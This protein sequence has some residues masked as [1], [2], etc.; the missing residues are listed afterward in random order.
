[1]NPDGLMDRWIKGNGW[2]RWMMETDNGL[3]DESNLLKE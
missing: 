2:I 1:M 3:T